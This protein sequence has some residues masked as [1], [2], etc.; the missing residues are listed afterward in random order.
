MGHSYVVEHGHQLRQIV[1]LGEAGLGAEAFPFR[2]KLHGGDGLAEVGCPAVEEA[3]AL[4]LQTVRLKIPLHGKE[5]CHGIGHRRTRG[6][7]NTALPMIHF[8]EIPALLIHIHGLFRI[9]R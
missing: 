9:G 8:I 4:V 7:D 2:G 5:F 3:Q 6:K 1:E